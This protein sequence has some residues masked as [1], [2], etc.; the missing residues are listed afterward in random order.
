MDGLWPSLLLSLWILAS[1]CWALLFLFLLLLIFL[2]LLLTF[3]QLHGT[4]LAGLVVILDK[5]LRSVL[6]RLT[7]SP[8]VRKNH[9]S[10]QTIHRRVVL[11]LIFHC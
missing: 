11:P 5:C 6:P 9:G 10:F 7:L 1:E 8:G 3:E 2:P 4:L